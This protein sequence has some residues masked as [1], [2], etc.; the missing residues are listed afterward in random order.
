MDFSAGQ[1]R[2][3]H[4]NKLAKDCFASGKIDVM[5]W[6]AQSSDQNPIENFWGNVKRLIAAANPSSRTQIWPVV[7]EAYTQIP[8]KREQDLVHSM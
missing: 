3:K 8:M 7:N 2:T 6:P 5:S 1:R 4:T